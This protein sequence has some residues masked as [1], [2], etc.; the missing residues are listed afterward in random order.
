MRHIWILASS[1]LVFS[2]LA[3]AQHGG[4]MGRGMVSAAPAVAAAPHAVAAAPRT[5]VAVHAAASHGSTGVRAGAPPLTGRQAAVYAPVQ[6][7]AV[8]NHSFNIMSGLTNLPLFPTGF[9]NTPGL[10]FDYPH[11]AAVG[12]GRFGPFNRFNR[13]NQGFG[14]GFGGFLLSPEVVVVEPQAG[15]PPVVGPE[16]NVA[17]NQAPPGGAA[18]IEDQ[19]LP[20]AAASTVP[21][22]VA[23]YVFVRRDGTLLFA[24]AYSW[25]NGTLRYITRDGVRRSIT[26]DALD[27]E[28]TQQFNEQRG[29]NFR[30][31]A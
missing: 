15:E 18:S 29:V 11:L 4:G 5:G 19:F 22:D 27:M 14:F 24:V 8:Q 17:A 28:A 3:F 10:G 16:E 23:E 12:N 26:Q 20:S 13:F 25:D 21:P 2:P 7:P 30:L 1:L 31:P 6:T 9:G